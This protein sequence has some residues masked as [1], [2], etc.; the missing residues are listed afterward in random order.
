M[1]V[2][3]T[4]VVHGA[5]PEDV[6]RMLALHNAAERVAVFYSST[7]GG[8]TSIALIGLP[9]DVDWKLQAIAHRWTERSRVELAELERAR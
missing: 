8:S 4:G 1:I 7:S 3:V 9:A 6:Q 2:H 5:Y